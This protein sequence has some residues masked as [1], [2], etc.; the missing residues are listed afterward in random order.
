MSHRW[1]ILAVLAVAVLVVLALPLREERGRLLPGAGAH[2][3]R[4]SVTGIIFSILGLVQI[5]KQPERFTGRG[6]AIAGIVIGIVSL[7]LVVVLMILGVALNWD[8]IRKDLQN[9]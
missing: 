7:V 1:R 3:A 5:R 9:A 6:L 8:E 2:V 4:F